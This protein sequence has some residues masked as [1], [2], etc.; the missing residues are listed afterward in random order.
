MRSR[1]SAATVPFAEAGWQSEGWSAATHF[2]LV[3]L[4]PFLDPVN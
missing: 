2:I 4:I 3:A 1:R